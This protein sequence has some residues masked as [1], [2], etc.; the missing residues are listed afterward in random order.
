MPVTMTGTGLQLP[1]TLVQKAGA[2]RAI[3]WT[4]TTSVGQVNNGW[5]ADT[6]L[7][8][9]VTMPPAKDSNSKYLIFCRTGTDDS[10]GSTSGFGLSVW[11]DQLGNG[12]NT[13]W[14]RRQG[15][16][17]DYWNVG[18]DKYFHTHHW[19][20]DMP[21]ETGNSPSVAAGHTRKYRVY[22]LANNSSIIANCNYVYLQEDASGLLVVMEIDGSLYTNVAN[23]V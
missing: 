20:L 18:E 23:N 12:A 7:N 9:E 1:S 13:Q 15:Y 21:G 17:A 6:Y 2:V 4:S 22:G 8:M 3:R 10:N 16:H 11:V 5:S 14:V 19:V